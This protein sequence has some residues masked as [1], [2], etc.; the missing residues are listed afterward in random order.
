MEAILDIFLITG[1]AVFLLFSCVGVLFFILLLF[2]PKTA[3]SISD[4]FDRSLD[5]EKNIRVLNGLRETDAIAYRHN[6]VS[7]GLFIVGSLF[8]LHFLFFKLDFEAFSDIF[9]SSNRYLIIYEI[10]FSTL[11]IAA[12]LVCVVG[13]ILGFG[14]LFVPERLKK[15]EERANRWTDTQ[16]IANKLD[17]TR[18]DVDKVFFRY[19]IVFGLMGLA[20][21]ILLIVLI[22]HFMI[23]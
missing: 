2:F 12:K 20:I 7:G 10:V 1:E 18:Y 11:L 8:C 6:Y 17:D 13:F 21:S 4:F 15:I 5:L 23:R 19:P 9:F 22:I 3:L 14:L 16:H